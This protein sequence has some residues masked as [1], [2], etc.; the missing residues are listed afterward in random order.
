MISH[1]HTP[2]YTD[3][4]QLATDAHRNT[5]TKTFSHRPVVAYGYATAGTH[6]QKI[7]RLYRLI[8]SADYPDEIRATKISLGRHRLAQIKNLNINLFKT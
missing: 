6:E 3:K 2:T 8:L 4:K 5:R 1:G 7:H